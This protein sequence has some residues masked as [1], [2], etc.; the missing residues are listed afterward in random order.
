V[1]VGQLLTFMGGIPAYTQINPKLTP[2]LFELKG[3]ALDQREQ[4]LKHVLQEEP[5]AKPGTERRYSNASYALAAF[6]AERRTGRSWETLM[7]EEVFKPLGMAREVSAGPGARSVPTSLPCTA[8]EIRDTSRRRMGKPTS[9][10]PSRRPA[11]R[12][13]RFATLPDSPPMS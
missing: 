12:I 1:T 6:V 13:A 11:M 10:P 2:V 4:L 5:V 9:W 3:G 7:A 8:R